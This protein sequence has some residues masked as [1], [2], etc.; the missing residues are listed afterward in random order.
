MNL[1][2]F[3]DRLEGVRNHGTGFH[4]RCP[5][6]EDKSPSL[7]ITDGGDRALII[8]R[9]GCDTRDVLE[10]IGLSW[11]DTFAESRTLKPIKPSLRI[12]ERR[13]LAASLDLEFTIAEIARNETI[14]KPADVK[15]ARQAMARLEET[16][17]RY[18]LD[19]FQEITAHWRDKDFGRYRKTFVPTDETLEAACG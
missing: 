13:R 15:R 1:D 16:A 11:A 2:I 7:T 14:T 10:A 18:G 19:E 4:A 8:C 5:A 3:R 12:D 17:R 6:H 9:A